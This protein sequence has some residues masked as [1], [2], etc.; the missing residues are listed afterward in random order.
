[1]SECRNSLQTSSINSLIGI[2]YDIDIGYPRFC[3]FVIK[4]FTKFD[5]SAAPNMSPLTKHTTHTIK[6]RT[7]KI[8]II[9]TAPNKNQANSIN[10]ARTKYFLLLITSIIGDLQ[11]PHKTPTGWR[12]TLVAISST[13]TASQHCRDS[14]TFGMVPQIIIFT[15]E[16]SP[17]VNWKE[18]STWISFVWIIKSNYF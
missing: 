10:R 9:E 12:C 3:I 17:K 1:M 2:K 6:K 4:D 11:D 15:A 18:H 13:T 8:I 7:S 14:W 5:I 16:F